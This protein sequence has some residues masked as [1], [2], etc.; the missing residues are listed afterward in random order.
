MHNQR[1]IIFG[2]PDRC[3]KTTIARTL[4]K[5]LDIPYFKPSYQ[6]Y[7]AMK[8]PSAFRH[9]TTWA[10]PKLLDFITQT[11]QSVIMDRGFPCDYVYSKVMGRETDWETI[12]RLDKAYA[13]LGAVFV[14]TLRY[15]YSG[16]SDDW[17]KISMGRLRSLHDT[18]EEYMRGSSMRCVSI[19]SP[20]IVPG[21]KDKPYP[22]KNQ[23]A[24][25]IEVL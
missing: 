24:D 15:D 4:S 17:D 8:E 22:L 3:G 25:I 18:Y 16:I 1:I 7:Y 10:E 13:K 20:P 2:G 19:V 9:Q 5:V 14:A 6:Q 21:P 23:V 11:G 12:T